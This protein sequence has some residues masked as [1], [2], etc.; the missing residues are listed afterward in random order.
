ML[1]CTYVLTVYALKVENYDWGVQVCGIYS[2]GLGGM[3][4]KTVF[5]IYLNMDFTFNYVSIAIMYGYSIF[6]NLNIIKK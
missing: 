2:D 3:K 4:N 1:F 6:F 5:L